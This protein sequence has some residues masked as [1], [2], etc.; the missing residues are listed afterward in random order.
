MRNVNLV[1]NPGIGTQGMCSMVLGYENF[2]FFFLSFSFSPGI[3][4]LGQSNKSLTV[5]WVQCRG[6]LKNKSR[7]KRDQGAEHFK[8]LLVVEKVFQEKS[9][10]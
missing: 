10:L 2:F 9:S 4:L 8:L 6:L 7:P 3:G 1:R 5:V